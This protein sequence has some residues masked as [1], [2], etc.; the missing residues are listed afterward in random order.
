MVATEYDLL[1]A[2][3]RSRALRDEMKAISLARAARSESAPGPSLLDRL[4]SLVSRGAHIL[5]PHRKVCVG[6]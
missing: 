3:D 2:E 6:A 1:V 5:A 4:I